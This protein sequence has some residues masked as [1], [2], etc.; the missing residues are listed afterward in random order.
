MTSPRHVN[1]ERGVPTLGAFERRCRT[2]PRVPGWED[3]EVKLL[4]K[5]SGVQY[6]FLLNVLRGKRNCTLSFLVKIARYLGTS[7]GNLVNR[8]EQA[9]HRGDGADPTEDR[10]AH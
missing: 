1:W 10:R 4:A 3:T 7:P 8:I 2:G 6:G 5:A 9:Y